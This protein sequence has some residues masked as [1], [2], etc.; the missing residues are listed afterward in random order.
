MVRARWKIFSFFPT[1]SALLSL[2]R[3][4]ID[5][6]LAWN[7]NNSRRNEKRKERHSIESFI[8]W[9]S[10]VSRRLV[11]FSRHS[12]LLVC[13]SFYLDVNARVCENGWP[14]FLLHHFYR[15]HF[16]FGFSKISIIFRCS[17]TTSDVCMVNKHTDTLTL[18]RANNFRLFSFVFSLL[19]FCFFSTHFVHSLNDTDAGFFLA[20][21]AYVHKLHH[22]FSVGPISWDVKSIVFFSGSCLFR[23]FSFIFPSVEGFYHPE[24]ISSSVLLKPIRHR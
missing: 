15:Y 19:F 14:S 8:W 7:K 1:F 23:Y 21:F 12:S 11:S 5:I 17:R 6:I 24:R 16:R 9:H 4:F 13:S 10:T 2:R 18:L 3:A 20:I 22:I